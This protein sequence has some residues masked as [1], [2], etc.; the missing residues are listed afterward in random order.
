MALS[1]N[2]C[3]SLNLTNAMK[4]ILPLLFFI[5]LLSSAQKIAV[6]DRN[7]YE[8][9]AMMDA[10]STEVAAKGGLIVIKKILLWSLRDWN[11]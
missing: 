11:N 10:L 6:I 3:C 7:F 5:P 4:Q 2:Y 8:P 9:I 1:V